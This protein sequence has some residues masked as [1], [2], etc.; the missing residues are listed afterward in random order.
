MVRKCLYERRF[1]CSKLFFTKTILNKSVFQ[2]NFARVM[3]GHKTLKN[4]LFSKFGPIASI[5]KTKW[6]FD[7]ILTN[8]L[9]GDPLS[10]NPQSFSLSCRWFNSPSSWVA[11]FSLLSKGKQSSNPLVVTIKL[12]KKKKKKKKKNLFISW[13]LFAYI[14]R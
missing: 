7:H 6:N 3:F 4:I 14:S 12:P 5:M 9:K 10:Q 13:Y 8:V 1:L 11:L 2:I